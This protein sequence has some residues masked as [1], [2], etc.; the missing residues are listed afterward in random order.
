MGTDQYGIDTSTYLG[1][2]SL[3]ATASDDWTALLELCDRASARRWHHKSGGETRRREFKCADLEFT[4]WQ[5]I[6]QEKLWRLF[7][8]RRLYDPKPVLEPPH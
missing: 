7:N 8:K 5:L 3:V 2:G 4:Q 6:G 1:I